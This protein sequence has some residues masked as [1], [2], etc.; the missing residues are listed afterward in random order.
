M[1]L[2][3]FEIILKSGK[4]VVGYDKNEYD[5]SCDVA[6]EFLGGPQ[7][8]VISLGNL[9]GTQNLLVRKNEIAAMVISAGEVE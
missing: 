8:D 5:N 9:Q 4:V 7:N 6:Q 3:K 1:Y 2:W